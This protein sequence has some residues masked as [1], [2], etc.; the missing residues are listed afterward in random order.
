MSSL[1]KSLK[2][3]QRG[4]VTPHSRSSDQR[5]IQNN[6]DINN[7]EAIAARTILDRRLAFNVLPPSSLKRE[8]RLLDKV[9]SYIC[10]IYISEKY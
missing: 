8:R 7:N 10:N 4:V 9:I 1:A 6:N 2:N 3:N 5:T